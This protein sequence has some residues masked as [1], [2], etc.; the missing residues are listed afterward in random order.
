LRYG[1]SLLACLAVDRAALAESPGSISGNEEG[2]LCWWQ[3]LELTVIRRDLA[4]SWETTRLVVSP[5]RAAWFGRHL[6]CASL[7][8]IN[9]SAHLRQ[10]RSSANSV[11]S[12]IASS[13]R[14]LRAADSLSR[15]AQGT[16]KCRQGI[17]PC[18]FGFD[19]ESLK[20]KADNLWRVSIA[21]CTLHQ[22]GAERAYSLERGPLQRV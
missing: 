15:V 3:V 13:L 9:T 19:G 5:L 1:S 18:G 11:Q 16:L 21:E 12:S 22:C 8:H 6:R 2:K 10:M 20:S 17:L 7:S 4:F 14:C